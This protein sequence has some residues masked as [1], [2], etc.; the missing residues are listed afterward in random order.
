V[1][2]QKGN[3]RVPTWEDS[4]SSEPCALNARRRA[5]YC[6]ARCATTGTLSME[7]FAGSM[8]VPEI[9][10]WEQPTSSCKSPT[11]QHGHSRLCGEADDQSFGLP[12]SRR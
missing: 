2:S 1:I 3:C 7:L 12:S 8:I 11:D 9:F 6:H 4:A 10:V 5:S